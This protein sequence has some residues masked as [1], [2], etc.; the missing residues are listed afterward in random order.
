[1]TLLLGSHLLALSLSCHQSNLSL[2][3]SFDGVGPSDP[4]PPLTERSSQPAVSIKIWRLRDCALNQPSFVKP[5]DYVV[6]RPPSFQREGKA[7]HCHPNPKT[8]LP[9][10][11]SAVDTERMVSDALWLDRRTDCLPRVCLVSGALATFVRM[12]TQTAVAA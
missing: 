10:G 11:P 5:R 4:L 12:P 6:W 9:G 3:P 2:M 1:M 7:T 8:G